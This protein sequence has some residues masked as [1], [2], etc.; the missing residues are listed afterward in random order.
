MVEDFST[1][2]VHFQAALA[3]SQ[4]LTPEQ[5]AEALYQ[6][7]VA[8]FRDGRFDEAVA[9][10][11]RLLTEY[12]WGETAVYF[13]LARAH[14][15]LGDQTAA[16]TAYQTYLQVNPDMAAYVNPRLAE[17]YL[18]LGEVDSA[19]AALEAALAAPAHRLT[20]I[21]IRRQLAQFYLDSGNY[22]AA[23]SQYDA[24][25]E[26]AVTENTQGEMTYLAGTAELMAGNTEAAYARYLTGI[27]SYPRAYKSYLGLIALVEAGIPVDMF[28]R[29]LV[30]FYA[31]AYQPA[32][33]AFRA[34][35]EANPETYRADAHL[36]LAWSYE[37][38]G[39]LPTALAELAD[40]GRAHPP[41]A[42]IETAKMYARA[43]DWT[44][45]I[46]G[47]EQ[48]LATY[49]E[50][51]DAPF[52]A[53]WSAALAERMGE[54]QTAVS[55]YERLANAYGWH[56]DAPEALFRAGWLAYNNGDTDT[57]IHLW[58]RAAQNYP[59][60][61][62]GAAGLV[63]L[64]K[65]L[66]AR[67][68]ETAV[69]PT[70]TLTITPTL[71]PT[72]TAPVTSTFSSPAETFV[73]PN[74][75]E[76]YAQSRRQA[77]QLR[78]TGYYGLRAQDLAHGREPFV[79]AVPPNLPHDPAAGQ[80][81]AEAWLRQW[82]G[83]SPNTDVRTLS[84]E[85]AENPRLKIGQKLWQAGLFE[86]AKRELEA[87]RLSVNDDPLL[88]YQLALYFRDLGLYRSSILAAVNLL[89][90]SGETVFTAPRFIGRLAYPVYY[91]NLIM[92]LANSYGFHP[93][94][95]FALVRQ[96][97]LFESFARSGAAAQ[98]LSQVIP[99]TGAYIARQLQ[100]PDYENEDLYRPYV[101][102]T[103]GAF[104][105]AQQ[106]QAF[107]GHVHAALAA[108]NAG[109]GNAARWY[110]QAGG[111]IDQF[112]EVVDFA[113]TRLYIERIYAGFAIYRYLYGGE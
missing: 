101:G 29:G 94:L 46:D 85:L 88:T 105:L 42:L 12:E 16:I 48:Y 112:V 73:L 47:Y 24:I 38:I 5:Q 109:P 14:T 22:A 67:L 104:Y 1:A 84:P 7:G 27:T 100:W 93:L 2:I 78:N 91:A 81:E 108:Y 87:V 77:F 23:I 90:L 63:W 21:A 3:H 59:Q 70:A 8:S 34:Y 99:D 40:Y 74:L 110:S 28:Q 83:L 65:V 10:F 95:Q 52:A 17:L 39:D 107:D 50:G 13:Y 45:A 19:L 53:W 32:I 33:A 11:D 36:Y 72:T 43:G 35:I 6:L 102:L 113:E 54:I 106:L 98:G 96:E 18:A 64:L 71:T 55:R 60:A 57:A 41:E 58:Q 69:S 86:E 82:L 68:A 51:R 4:T 56:Q 26:M 92:P 20:H 37:A 103:F 9:A 97:S 76:L 49:P 79:T 62:Y 30:D 111:E 80:A 31:K 15:A 61:D 44:A 89:T 75:E 66:P 25:R